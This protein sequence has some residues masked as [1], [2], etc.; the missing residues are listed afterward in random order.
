MAASPTKPNLI[1]ELPLG[2]V[3]GELSEPDPWVVDPHVQE[4]REA[5]QS[6]GKSSTPIREVRVAG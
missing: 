4:E 2:L 3:R 5:I 6:D 1:W